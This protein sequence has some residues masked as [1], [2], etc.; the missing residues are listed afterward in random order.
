[1]PGGMGNVVSVG[2]AVGITKG[3]GGA[4]REKAPS[5]T[6]AFSPRMRAECW[7][8]PRAAAVSQ[9]EAGGMHCA[10]REASGEPFVSYCAP[11]LFGKGRVRHRELERSVAV[12]EAAAEQ[13]ELGRM[14]NSPR[15]VSSN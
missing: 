10:L 3:E 14:N 2:T 6:H 13:C 12:G 1:M 9:K 7:F 8:A 11:V 5:G 15:I 4:E